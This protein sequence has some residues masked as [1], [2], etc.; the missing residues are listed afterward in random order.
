MQNKEVKNQFK[1]FSS[2]QLINLWTNNDNRGALT[3]IEGNLDIPFKIKRCYFLHDIRMPRGGHAH[4]ETSQMMVA[5]SGSCQVR[6][7]DGYESKNFNLDSPSIGLYFDPML[8]I[9][10][11]TFSDD[12]TILVIANTHYDNKKTIR[13]WQEYLKI[14]SFLNK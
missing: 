6:L 9:E 13:D 1:G 12:A 2:V 14:V 4:R 7:S 5:V 10:I 3:V 11:P 8:W